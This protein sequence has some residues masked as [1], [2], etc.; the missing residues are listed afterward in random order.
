MAKIRLS[1]IASVGNSKF[2]TF[3]DLFNILAAAFEHNSANGFQGVSHGDK[4]GDFG[5]L[6]DRI[7][8]GKVG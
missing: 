8:V 4:V 3:D 6:M 7:K 5:D 2:V 1:E